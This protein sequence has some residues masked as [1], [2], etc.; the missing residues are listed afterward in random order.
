MAERGASRRSIARR[1]GMSEGTVRYYVRQW[2]E[3]VVDG[4]SEN[5]FRAQAA[6]AFDHGDVSFCRGLR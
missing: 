5:P 2:G 1:L 4:R 6:A 3:E